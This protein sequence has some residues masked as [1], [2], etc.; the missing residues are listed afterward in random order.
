M[1]L[2][3]LVLVESMLVIDIMMPTI[4][5]KYYLINKDSNSELR[6]SLSFSHNF[7]TQKYFHKNGMHIK[8]PSTRQ[9]LSSYCYY[10]ED[11][12][13]TSNPLMDIEGFVFRSLKDS[14]CLL[15]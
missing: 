8:V 15:L 4:I 11:L 6:P 2:E 3:R 7:L 10:L 12:Y 14:L 1:M 13:C 5:L 9:Y